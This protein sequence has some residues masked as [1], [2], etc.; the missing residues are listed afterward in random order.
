MLLQ[1]N[2]F[3]FY[4]LVIQFV[5]RNQNKCWVL[6]SKFSFCIVGVERNDLLFFRVLIFRNKNAIPH[7]YENK[8]AEI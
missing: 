8:K 3:L 6:P 4:Y 5:Q 1:R 7:F 2:A